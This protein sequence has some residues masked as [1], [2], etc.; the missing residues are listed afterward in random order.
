MN[1][2]ILGTTRAMDQDLASRSEYSP[3]TE[4]SAFAEL[5]RSEGQVRVLDVFLTK[6]HHWL[7]QEDLKELADV[8]QSTVSRAVRKLEYIGSIQ[9]DKSSDTNEYALDHDQPLVE[10]LLDAYTELLA[11]AEEFVADREDAGEAADVDMNSYSTGS[12]L[13]ELCRTP[14]QITLL[15]LFLTKE[16]VWMSSSDIQKLTGLDKNTVSDRLQTL[17]DTG[18]IQTDMDEWPRLHALNPDHPAVPGLLETHL[19]LIT[20]HDEI[21]G[22]Q[23]PEVDDV[24]SSSQNQNIRDQV[25]GLVSSW[26]DEPKESGDVDSFEE[27]S[28]DRYSTA[29]YSRGRRGATAA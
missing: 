26:T 28:P 1:L 19:H 29:R 11:H 18:I 9:S 6:S 10:T 20:Y 17:R 22:P 23:T 24:P 16:H 4:G 2:R 5:L 12:P 14:S 13:V 25:K 8:D 3:Y 27:S 21:Q 7:T 15:D